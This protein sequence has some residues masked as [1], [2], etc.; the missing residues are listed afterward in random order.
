[1]RRT[2][3]HSHDRAQFGFANDPLQNTLERIG[4]FAKSLPIGFCSCR[5][6][7]DGS[8]LNPEQPKQLQT[9][10]PVQSDFHETGFDSELLRIHRSARG[11]FGPGDREETEQLSEK[12]E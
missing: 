9:A 7:S 10:F 3:N 12:P 6:H 8:L 11:E 2:A 5:Q 4:G 1:L